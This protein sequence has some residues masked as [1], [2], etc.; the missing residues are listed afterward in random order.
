MNISERP[1]FIFEMANNHQG[2]VDL[3]LKII[4]ELAS[5]KKEFD[6][7]FAVKMQYRDLDTFIHP[8]HKLSSSD[9][10]VNR[11]MGTRLM[12]EQ[13]LV[14]KNEIVKQGFYSICTPFDEIS[15]KTVADHGY[16]VIKIASCSFS[17][18]PLLERI[19]QCDK[20][21]IAS[22]AGVDI[23]DID[24]VVSF[25]THRNKS[26]ALMHCVAEYPTSLNNLQLNQIN[27]LGKR[28][29]GLIIGY[30]THEN[31]DNFDSVKMAISKGARI[32]EKHVGINTETVQLNK[33]SATPE[34]LVKWL[35]SAR[36]AF[37]MCGKEGDRYQFTRK[38]T[39]DL[40][41]L[42]RGVFARGPIQ[43]GEKID[44]SNTYY[45]IPNIKGQV[46]ANDISKYKSYFAETD[47][48][49]DGPVYFKNVKLID[50]RGRVAEIIVQVKK[51]VQEAGISVPDGLFFE[52]SHH[53]GIDNFPSIGA[54]IINYINREY[55]KKIIIMVPGQAHPEH[56]HKRKEETF[57]VL[58][59]DIL[60][61]INGV[62]KH[63]RQGD[64]VLVDRGAVHSFSTTNGGI[65]EEISTTH[66]MNDSYYLDPKIIENKKRK[67]ELTYWRID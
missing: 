24:N 4:H 13:F 15:V 10:M 61:K 30:S 11:F 25:F 35:E 3:G 12:K 54:S 50:V 18:W 32:F 26:I 19:A 31:P 65:F 62:E 2:D 67:T 66:Y 42:R 36:Q 21:V 47:I 22:V 45:A 57:H 46:L 40:M 44:D 1:L 56:Y 17:D 48:E 51:L 52:L 43:K 39:D 33:Y 59:G 64:L 41:S 8:A 14:L 29:P 34:Q 6:F 58:H 37:I 55:C 49:K 60:I 23:N 7:N 63:C 16:D 9:K 5:V 28:Y 20:P 27:L 38:E 53:Y